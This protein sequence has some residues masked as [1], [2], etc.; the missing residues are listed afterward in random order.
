MGLRIVTALHG[1][2]LFEASGVR[3]DEWEVRVEL[4]IDV[5]TFPIAGGR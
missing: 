4:G 3:P 5:T 2:R 1:E